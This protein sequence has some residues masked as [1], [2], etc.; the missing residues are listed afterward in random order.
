MP[1]GGIALTAA[2]ALLGVVLNAIVPAQAFEI[3]LNISAL[4]IIASWATI[5]L[6]QME[7]YRLAKRGRGGASRVPAVRRAVHRLR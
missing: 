5:I 1:Y 6:C 3:V 7:L 2:I 4:G